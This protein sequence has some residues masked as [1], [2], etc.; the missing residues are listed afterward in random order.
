MTNYKTK[1]E[2]KDFFIA[3]DI[4]RQNVWCSFYER[5]PNEV[6]GFVK[7]PNA[8]FRMSLGH[9]WSYV[10]DED[11]IECDTTVVIK[12]GKKDHKDFF[13]KHNI[14]TLKR[15]KEFR[16]ENPELVKPYHSSCHKFTDSTR[17]WF[18]YVWDKKIEKTKTKEEHR[19]FFMLHN[20]GSSREWK[21]FRKKN[22]NLVTSYYCHPH[23]YFSGGSTVKW[24]NYVWSGMP[25]YQSSDLTDNIVVDTK[26]SA[27]SSFSYSTTI[28]LA[29]A[30]NLALDYQKSMVE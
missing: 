23:D 27:I 16:E 12:K 14:R 2:Y 25:E 10:C 17:E 20:I 8:K 24:Y 1:Q 4:F 18:N 21:E 13:I 29:S 26:E 28:T 30:E 3:N 6:R 7:F 11:Y 15:W 5:N 19:L 9:W 22:K